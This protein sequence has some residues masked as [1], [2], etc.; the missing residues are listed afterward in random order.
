LHNERQP[1]LSDIR[2]P[3]MLAWKSKLRHDGA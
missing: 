2:L 3:R 1:D